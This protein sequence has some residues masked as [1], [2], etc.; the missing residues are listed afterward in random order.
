MGSLVGVNAGSAT[1]VDPCGGIGQFSEQSAPASAWMRRC[2]ET[3]RR[4]G[5]ASPE[6]QCWNFM[7]RCRAQRI[8]P[9]F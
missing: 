4:D 6:A 1:I 2:V 5:Y 9:T 3:M 7:A 8:S